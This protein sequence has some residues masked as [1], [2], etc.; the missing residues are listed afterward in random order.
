MKIAE[1]QNGRNRKAYYAR[2]FL[3]QWPLIVAILLSGLLF[4]K[5]SYR[6]NKNYALT[7]GVEPVASPLGGEHSIQLSYASEQGII[8]IL[9]NKASITLV[10]RFFRLINKNL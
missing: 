2:R 8:A 5:Y 1:N 9:L 10:L 7:T 4:R 3:K 6:S